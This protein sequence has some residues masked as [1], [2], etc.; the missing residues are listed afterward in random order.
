MMT[1][2]D[3]CTSTS[4]LPFLDEINLP[5]SLTLVCDFQLFGEV[6]IP[7][8][9]RVNDRVRRKNVLSRR[10]ILRKTKREKKKIYALQLPSPHSALLRQRHR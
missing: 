1:R 2:D 7:H 6:I 10:E 8:T 9:S 5:Q 3:D 4:L